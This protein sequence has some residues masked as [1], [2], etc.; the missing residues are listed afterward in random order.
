MLVTEWRERDHGE[1]DNE[2]M[3]DL[4]DQDALRQCGFFNFFHCNRIRVQIR[5]L[6]TLI[7]YYKLE[8]YIFMIR[9]R[10]LRIETEDIYFLIGLP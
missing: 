1:V 7:D 3:N 8:E 9:G 5:L 6:E 10:Y 4:N 2:V